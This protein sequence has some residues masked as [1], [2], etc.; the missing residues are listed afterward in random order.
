[1]HLVALDKGT[2]ALVLQMFHRHI[3]SIAPP[4]IPKLGVPTT[5]PSGKPHDWGAFLR[6]SK[7]SA[8]CWSQPR[9]PPSPRVLA[10][11]AEGVARQS[12]VGWVDFLPLA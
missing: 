8:I 12:I 7:E 4:R 6:K 2:E 1:V 5:R 9:P 10:F 11:L 3:L